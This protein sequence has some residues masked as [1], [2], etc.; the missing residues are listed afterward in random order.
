[1]S[2]MV[3]SSEF[4]TVRDSL[5]DLTNTTGSKLTSLES[6]ME[7]IK[8]D[9]SVMNLSTSVDQLATQIKQLEV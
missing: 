5:H 7:A 3:V 1:M 6:Q 8:A 2:D 4:I 9:D